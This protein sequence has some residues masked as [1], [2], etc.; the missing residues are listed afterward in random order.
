MEVGGDCD[1]AKKVKISSGIEVG[2]KLDG[3]VGR[4]E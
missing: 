4:G 2:E 1:I 3:W